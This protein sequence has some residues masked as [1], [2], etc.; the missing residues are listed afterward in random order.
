MTQTSVRS[1]ALW[2]VGLVA[3]GSALAAV[4]AGTQFASGMLVGGVAILVGLA[5]STV[6]SGI[7]FRAP[8]TFSGNLARLG[9]ALKLPVM[10]GVVW[11][12]F[13]LFPVLAVVLGASSLVLAISFD[14]LFR[15][16]TSF[17]S[18]EV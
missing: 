10:A 7:W 16:R 8:G 14:A 1:V 13:T 5:V 2:T 9:L 18:W 12:L 6:L 3:G 4:V 11:W 15:S 17:A